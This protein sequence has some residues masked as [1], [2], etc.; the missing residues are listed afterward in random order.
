MRAAHA[1]DRNGRAPGRPGPSSD[2]AAQLLQTRLARLLDALPAAQ[3]GDVDSV[4][5]ARV[6]SRR[7]REALPVAAGG[8]SGWRSARRRARRITRA[9]GPV[10]DIDVA[11]QTLEEFEDRAVAAPDAF[12]CVRQALM[13]SRQA[14]RA[15]MLGA[16][17]PTL[18]RK[19]QRRLDAVAT[20][21]APAD[22]AEALEEARRRVS[23]RAE[24]LRA[25]IDHA[26]AVYLADRLHAVRIAAKKLRYAM[27]LQ[28]EL[29]RSRATARIRRLKD[30]QDHLGRLHDLEMLIEHT[31]AV[32]ADLASRRMATAL[33]QLVRAL[34]DECR[35]LHGAYLASRRALIAICDAVSHPSPAAA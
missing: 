17:T 30:A 22:R 25:A 6:A 20:R 4:H 1:G 29:Q 10:R 3:A 12:Q 32:Q 15:E 27:E 24:R 8:D 7:L 31:R 11:L 28:R 19:L 5:R 2:P 26:G 13:A 18:L 14:R 9:L 35:Q 23:V 33:D 34:E 21:P 16:V